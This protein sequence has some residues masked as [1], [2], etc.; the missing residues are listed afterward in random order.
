MLN[1]DRHRDWQD[2]KAWLLHRED[3]DRKARGLKPLEVEIA[4]QNS[5]LKTQNLFTQP[6]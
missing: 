3:Q 6:A 4:E 5:S 1:I 2:F